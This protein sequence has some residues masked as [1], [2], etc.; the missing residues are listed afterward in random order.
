MPN[1]RRELEDSARRYQSATV[2]MN[3][4][5]GKVTKTEPRQLPRLLV[6]VEG[7]GTTANRAFLRTGPRI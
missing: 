1:A 5:D 7:E 3:A 4:V 6:K 2:V